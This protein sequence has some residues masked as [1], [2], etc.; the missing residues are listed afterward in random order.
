MAGCLDVTFDQM[1]ENL[2]RD[3][4]EEFMGLL[5]EV[6]I[7]LNEEGFCLLTLLLHYPPFFHVSGKFIFVLFCIKGSFFD[8]IDFF[9]T[10]SDLLK[11]FFVLFT[12]A[13]NVGLVIGN[14]GINIFLKI[15]TDLIEA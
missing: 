4:F 11:F 7:I 1:E 8:G 3:S 14:F 9:A 12:E 13:L 2:V 10:M 5:M 15:R 6:L